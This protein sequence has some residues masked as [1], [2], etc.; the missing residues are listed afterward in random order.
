MLKWDSFYLTFG[1][2]PKKPRGKKKVVFLLKFQSEVLHLYS[3]CKGGCYKLVFPIL[4]NKRID[5]E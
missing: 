5:V 3:I 2:G 4:L 1:C